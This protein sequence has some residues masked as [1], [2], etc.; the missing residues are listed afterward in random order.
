MHKSLIGAIFCRQQAKS[1]RLEINQRIAEDQG[2]AALGE[3]EDRLA[4]GRSLDGDRRQSGDN[5]SPDTG[6]DSV[7]TQFTR[8]RLSGENCRI[9]LF[10]EGDSGSVVVGVSD[11]DRNDSS[12]PLQFGEGGG[13]KWNRVDEKEA[14]S[15][16]DRAGE[17]VGF[18]RWIV[19]LPEPDSIGQIS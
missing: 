19:G 16:F 15:V 1:I 5:F 13:T 18:H 3:M 7:A 4:W 2:A 17:K 6:S 12:L 8:A 10:G 14:V 11:K 9:E